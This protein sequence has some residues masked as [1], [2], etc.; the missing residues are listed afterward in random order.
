M[1]DEENAARLKATAAEKHRPQAR[2]R[3]S[4][5]F[6]GVRMLEFFRLRQALSCPAVARK[7]LPAGGYE[8]NHRNAISAVDE[9]PGI[10]AHLSAAASSA[11]A[12]LRSQ[13]AAHT[14]A[15]TM[16]MNAR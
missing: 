9:R 7:T 4:R 1:R 10:H 2:T 12:V 6:F 5:R 11:L 14:R 13:I 3:Y 16:A 15:T 8:E